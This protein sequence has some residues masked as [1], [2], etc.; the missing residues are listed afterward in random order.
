M[1]QTHRSHGFARS[2]IAAG[3]NLARIP[4]VLPVAQDRDTWPVSR[5]VEERNWR[6]KAPCWASWA[7]WRELAASDAGGRFDRELTAARCPGMGT[8]PARSRAE[9][10]ALGGNLPSR[11]MVFQRPVGRR[12]PPPA[13]NPTPF[14]LPTAHVFC[15]QIVLVHFVP[16][17][18]CVSP[19]DGPSA[20]TSHTAAMRGETNQ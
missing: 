16:A 20:N 3:R 10:P 14:R 1:A 13:I 5:S 12:N 7:T 11:R 18:V 9:Q 6:E 17:P 4:E 19:A 15:N 2:S 8:L